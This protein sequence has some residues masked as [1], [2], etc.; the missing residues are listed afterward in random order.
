MCTFP[1][2][3]ILVQVNTFL[4][5]SR[6]K[7][8]GKMMPNDFSRFSSKLQ[9]NI[10]LNDYKYSFGLYKEEDRYIY[11]LP[12]CCYIIGIGYID[13]FCIDV[14]VFLETFINVPMSIYITFN[15]LGLLLHSSS[16][17]KDERVVAF[18]GKKR[19]G[20][21]TILQS[22]RNHNELG[23]TFYSDDTLRIQPDGS[24]FPSLPIIK[25]EVPLEAPLIINASNNK[26]VYLVDDEKCTHK[27]ENPH[28][29]DRII[30]LR[31]R[32]NELACS[33]ISNKEL[34]KILV[35]QNI[36]GYPIFTDELKELAYKS[37]H[38]IDSI[39]CYLVS[40]PNDISALSDSLSKILS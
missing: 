20:K 10:Y 38:A 31:N 1:L 37:A 23:Y 35:C 27:Y 15:Q 18:S 36:S 24:V 9:L 17:E 16:V 26:G 22:I 33:H 32:S 14:D 30:F 11:K 3:G 6:L 5:D 2:Y 4:K 21:S 8:L 39:K 19:V 28:Q 13:V 40:F 29:M 25:S 12:G 34:S 7:F